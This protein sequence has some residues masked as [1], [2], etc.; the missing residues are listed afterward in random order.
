MVL[1]PRAPT[2]AVCPGSDKEPQRI[3][4]DPQTA[5]TI[6]PVCNRVFN[7]TRT[8]LLPRHLA[9]PAWRKEAL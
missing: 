6:C 8:K 3:F 1:T 7:L 5:W 9:R 4:V 2:G